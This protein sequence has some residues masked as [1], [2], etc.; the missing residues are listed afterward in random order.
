LRSF[1]RAEENWS[2]FDLLGLTMSVSFGRIKAGAF[3]LPLARL[4]ALTPPQDTDLRS[5][6]VILA[7]FMKLT[8]VKAV[9]LVAS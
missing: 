8:A 7:A 9:E 3:A 5:A 4:V 2:D 1:A 6:A